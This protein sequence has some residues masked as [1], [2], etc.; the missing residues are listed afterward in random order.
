MCDMGL[1]KPEKILS[2]MSF[3]DQEII[4]WYHDYIIF[5]ITQK[6]LPYPLMHPLQAVVT[7][8]WMTT[9]WYLSVPPRS[10]L[11]LGVEW[12]YAAAGIC[13]SAKCHGR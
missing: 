8:V 10:Q 1:G 6:D 12:M 9:H 2:T 11:P 3:S 4:P 13:P 7:W 5:Y